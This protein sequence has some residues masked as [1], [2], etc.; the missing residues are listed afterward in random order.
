MIPKKNFSQEKSLYKAPLSKTSLKE[1]Q[2]S[3]LEATAHYSFSS[4]CFKGLRVR[5]TL[6]KCEKE[7]RLNKF[8]YCNVNVAF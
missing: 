2:E 6:A 8:L 1:E 7:E 4:S 5:A 3:S